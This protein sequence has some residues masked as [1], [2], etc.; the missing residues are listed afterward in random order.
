MGGFMFTVC[1]KARGDAHPVA[2]DGAVRG[3]PGSVDGALCIS[4]M[5][6]HHSV[7]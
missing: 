5:R 2:H 4:G 6:R 7:K 3:A 1:P